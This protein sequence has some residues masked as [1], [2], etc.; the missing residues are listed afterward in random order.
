MVVCVCTKKY[1]LVSGD[2]IV[3]V[4][5]CTERY[6]LVSGEVVLV[7]RFEVEV[8]NLVNVGVIHCAEY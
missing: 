6:C 5:R 8:V 4:S 2:V 7:S 3:L 1:F